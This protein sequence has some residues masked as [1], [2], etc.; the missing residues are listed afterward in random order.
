MAIVYTTTVTAARVSSQDNL[1]DVIKELDAT[2][3][4]QDGAVTFQLS[5]SVTL[6][7]A[8][9][10]AFTD[11]EDLTEEKLVE[12]VEAN[13]ALD[14]VRAHIAYVVAKEVER[15]ALHGKPLPWAPEPTAPV[16]PTDDD[17]EDE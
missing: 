11:Y 6:G 12:W 17:D 7:P 5:T 10:E 16:L 9:P 14:S 15:A 13:P 1:N 4:G 2:V 8:D 3:T